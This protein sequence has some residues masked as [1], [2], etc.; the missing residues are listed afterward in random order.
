MT[1]QIQV[2]KTSITDVAHGAKAAIS[3]VADKAKAST[4]KLAGATR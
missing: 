3:F 2:P 4:D 1:K